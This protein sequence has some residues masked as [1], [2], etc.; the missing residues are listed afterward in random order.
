MSTDAEYIKEIDEAYDLALDIVKSEGWKKEKHDKDTDTLVEMKKNE[1]GRKIY[2]GKAKIKMSQ[3]AMVEAL[4]NTDTVKEWNTTLLES[5]TLKKL[6]DKHQITYQVTTDSG[7]G[8][9][10]SR[11]FVY[12]SK[13]DYI[14]GET[15]DVFVMGGKSVDYPDAPKVNKIVRAINGAGCQMVIP[16]PGED[17]EC[18]VLWLMDCDFKGWMPSNILDVA[19][20]IAQTQFFDSLRKLAAKK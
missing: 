20:P 8:L 1:K 12:G 2:R 4:K 7:G 3:Q 9:V 16:V 6:D 11:D 19:M 5:K 17:G 18:E 15:G 10:S 13:F 14:K